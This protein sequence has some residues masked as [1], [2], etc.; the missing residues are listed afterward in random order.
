MAEI[1][2]AFGVDAT[3]ERRSVPFRRPQAERE[4]RH[5][6]WRL[7]AADAPAVERAIVPTTLGGQ[8]VRQPLGTRKKTSHDHHLDCP[9]KTSPHLSL[10][11]TWL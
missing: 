6:A 7:A 11:S 2:Q 4:T 5:V 9:P 3:P 8:P 10:T 1:R